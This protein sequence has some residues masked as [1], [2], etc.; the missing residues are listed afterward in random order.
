MERITPN[1]LTSPFDPLYLGN[2]TQQINYITSKGKYAM[3]QPHNY[4]RFYGNIITDT[5][6]FK[7][8]W[9]NL[10]TLYKDNNLVVFDTNNGTVLCILHANILADAMDHRIPR[11]GPTTR[12][13]SEPGGD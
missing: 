9:K 13:R 3:I 4:G 8:W 6:G 1:T 5:S 7:T 12:V 10:A 2:L 11:H